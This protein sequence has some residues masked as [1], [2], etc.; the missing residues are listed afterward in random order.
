[1][2]ESKVVYFKMKKILLSKEGNLNT[3]QQFRKIRPSRVFWDL[4]TSQ[5]VSV[6]KVCTFIF[7]LVICL[8]P[9]SVWSADQ[10]PQ[11]IDLSLL[12]ATDLPCSWPGAGPNFQINHYKRIGPQS[13]Y[14]SDILTLDENVGTQFD[15]PTHSVAPPDSKKPN[16]GP[17]GLISGDK[18]PAWQFVGEACVIDVRKLLGS[19]A[20][21]KSPLIFSKH[22]KAWEKENRPVSFGDVVLFYSGF[23]DRFYKPF[24]EGRAF[25]ADPILAKAFAWPDPAPELMEFLATRKVMTL[26]TDSPSMGPIPELAE[27]THFAGLKHGMI[28]T[29]GATNLGKL[30]A[31]GAFYCMLGIKHA[32]GIG[33]ETR[34]FAIT[35]APLVQ[36][37]LRS[38]RQK[39]V[40]DLSVL[41]ADNL[42][43]WWPG[44]G[45]G[46]N[47]HPYLRTIIP[48]YSMN[49]HLLDSHSGTHLVPPS[50]ALPS[51]GFDNSSYSSEVREWLSVY[52][53]KYGPRGTSEITTDKV[54][55]SQTSG[56]A[57]VINVQELSGTTDK[58]Q[59]P[60]SP[61]ITVDIIKN[62]EK[63]YGLLKRGEIVIFQSGFS[64]RFFKPFPEG[65]SFM[66]NPLNG[67]S[68]GWPAPGPDAILYLA[69]RGIRCVGT[70]GPTLGGVNQKKAL[71]TYWALGNSGMVGVESLTNLGS[72]P[73]KAYF[74]FAA[75]KIRNCHGGPGRAIALY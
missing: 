15:A 18:V 2:E 49:L 45:I 51:K 54:P 67:K 26:G 32:K 70:D 27:E 56:W 8:K 60:H 17:F 69:D 40:V 12:V 75:L 33:A 16:A 72:L 64:D 59:W 48:P 7:C 23:S 31:T 53:K 30:P 34:A 39:R 22:V 3:G 38:A 50:Y 29:E 65:Q 41:L 19:E 24:P 66:G 55:L 57:R 58:K 37:L 5:L 52:E 14:N 6:F 42:P 4:P 47:R 10:K 25:V 11:I 36:T 21:G 43:V 68:E 74:I 62:Y 46:N 71:M 35:G 13:P 73:D 61:E 63:R 9:I 20:I 1:M 28:W 44:T